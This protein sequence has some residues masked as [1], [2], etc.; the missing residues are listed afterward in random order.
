MRH[1][2]PVVEK[3]DKN[4]FFKRI[5]Q[6]SEQKEDIHGLIIKESC[7]NYVMAED[8]YKEAVEELKMKKETFGYKKIKV[9]TI[10]EDYVNN[11][12]INTRSYDQEGDFLKLMFE[13]KSIYAI[14]YPKNY[15]KLKVALRVKKRKRSEKEEP[16][17]RQKTRGPPQLSNL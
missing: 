5:L 9:G 1:F 12:A 15:L 3:I 14:Y 17:K 16:R 7:T 8:D 4:E 6:I 13:D 11:G 10:D 2:K